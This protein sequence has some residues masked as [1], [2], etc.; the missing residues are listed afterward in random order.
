MI[1]EWRFDAA[2]IN[3]SFMFQSLYRIKGII[4]PERNICWKCPH[5]QAVQVEMSLFLCQIWRNVSYH[6]ESSMDALQWMGAVRMSPNS[7]YITII[8][9]TPVHQ[10]TSWEGKSCVFVSFCLKYIFLSKQTHSSWLAW[11]AG[12]FSSNGHFRVNCSFKCVRSDSE[13]SCWLT[14]VFQKLDFHGLCAALSSDL[15]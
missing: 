5:P 3:N 2:F 12:S 6:C 11:A 4:N 10:L 9:T 14:S 15:L 1:N 8:H 13:V 7:W